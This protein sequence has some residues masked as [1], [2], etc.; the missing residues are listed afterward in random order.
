[1]TEENDTPLD[2]RPSS[3]LLVLNQ[4]DHVL[5]FKFDYRDGPLAGR[6]F[7]ATPGGGLDPGE[8]Y[9]AA[10][11]R[12]MM[13]ETGL[14][15]DDP[16]PQVAQRTWVGKVPDGRTVR[17][18]ERYFLIKVDLMQ[19]SERH[20]SDLERETIADHRWWSRADLNSTAEA[21]YPEDL[22]QVLD[23]AGAW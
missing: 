16:G 6:T 14:R 3:R 19:V 9:E 13:E 17:A 11:C 15:I 21:F 8:T 5:L 22:V 2:D 23:R 4:A 7:W 18:D 10:A 12:E 1:M 20:W